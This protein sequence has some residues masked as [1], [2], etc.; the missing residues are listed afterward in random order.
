M[1]EERERTG[2]TCE[3]FAD[4]FQRG[5]IHSN[6]S[7]TLLVFEGIP[8]RG[9]LSTSAVVGYVASK[10]FEVVDSAEADLDHR[11]HDVVRYPIQHFF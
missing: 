10:R 6:I 11:D 8:A 4:H 1:V 9:D 3:D 7:K 5:T 2:F